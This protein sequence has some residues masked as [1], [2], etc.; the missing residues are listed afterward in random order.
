[1]Q[2]VPR[3]LRFFDEV[4]TAPKRHRRGTHR[5]VAPADTVARVRRLMRRLGITRLA[6]LTGLDSLGLPVWSAIRPDGRS[7]STSQGKGLTHDHARAS[8]LMESVETWHAEHVAL[9]RRRATW[10][11]LR[12]EGTSCDVAGLPRLRRVTL[13][14]ELEWVRGWD[15]LADAP[16]WV[17]L[18][19]VTLDTVFPPGYAPAFDV[20]SNGLASG[21]HAL[22]AIA[23]G[24]C[25]VIER[26]AEARWRQQRG[27]IRVDLS[28]VR[29]RG[30]AAALRR[31]RASGVH[32]TVWDLDSDVGVPAY[33]CTI[34]E[35][36]DEPAWRALGVY[37]GFG[38][39][40]DPEVAV[41]RAVTE[42][43][44]TRVTYIAG[45]RD[46][47]FPWDYARATDPELHRAVWDAVHA[48]PRRWADLRD[49]PRLAGARF[50]DD[51]ARLLERLAAAGAT[52]ALVV[53]LARPALRV[54][55]VKC[56][57]PGRATHL[58]LMG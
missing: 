7:L 31:L 34:L 58:D 38:C 11:A 28:T 24:L 4:L 17:P 9:P 48:P 55:V 30:L 18:E 29:D 2:G 43:V 41:I 22:E 57:V 16:R 21:N 33:G 20:S 26:D 23:H 14:A 12:A 32:V 46:D 37:Q 56:F 52:S 5:V 50:E 13:D 6:D 45:S 27:D 1:M 19:A 15:L 54:P 49:A 36:P 39:H 35:D 10:R 51:V 42:A 40:L 44:Q 3:G 25:E 47:F 53:D 8:A